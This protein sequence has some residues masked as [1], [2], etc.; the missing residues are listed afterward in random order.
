MN[1]LENDCPLFEK[2]T[3]FIYEKEDLITLQPGRETAF[4]DAFVERI[5]ERMLKLCHYKPVQVSAYITCAR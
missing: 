4:L 5:I 2:E 3:S 1:F